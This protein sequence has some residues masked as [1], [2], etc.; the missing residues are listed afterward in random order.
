MVREFAAAAGAALV[1]ALEVGLEALITSDPLVG[2]AE[3]L[4][5]GVGEAVAVDRLASQ[6]AVGATVEAP[7]AVHLLGQL[8]AALELG[9]G[10]G[11]DAPVAV[12][13]SL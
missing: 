7:L 2:L 11:H 1:L 3:V 8:G 5:H 9:V 4:E 10:E 13:L 6:R 12:R